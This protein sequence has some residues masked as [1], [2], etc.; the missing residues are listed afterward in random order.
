[1]TQNTEREGRHYTGEGKGSCSV[2]LSV[3]CMCP[4]EESNAMST[5]CIPVRGVTS[6]IVVNPGLMFTVGAPSLK[7]VDGISVATT[8]KVFNI[9]VT[10]CDEK[11]VIRT[12][13]TFLSPVLV[14]T[15]CA[16]VNK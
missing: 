12:S 9:H 5:I 1:M 11:P 4:W 14:L 10:N 13:T 16:T 2:I 6:V 8:K 7:A 15:I 3:I